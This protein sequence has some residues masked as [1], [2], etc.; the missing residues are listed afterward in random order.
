MPLSVMPQHAGYACFRP[1]SS[2][3][4]VTN[5]CIQGDLELSIRE[6][7]EVALPTLPATDWLAQVRALVA[8][9]SRVKEEVRWDVG[10]TRF[11]VS[12]LM[13]SEN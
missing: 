12:Q 2:N 10:L 13:T 5:P 3:K 7:K 4:G 8:A 1:S 6:A 11:Q 9:E